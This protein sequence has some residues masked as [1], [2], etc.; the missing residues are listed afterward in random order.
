MKNVHH[1]EVLPNSNPDVLGW[2]VNT[3]YL[4]N[5]LFV[6]D[7]TQQIRQSDDLRSRKK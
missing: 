6:F 5:D 4:T 3:F 7:N 1:F 2:P